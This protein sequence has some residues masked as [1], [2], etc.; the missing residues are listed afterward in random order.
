MNLQNDEIL[1]S[2]CCITYNHDKY[3]AQA[4]EGFL[5][6]KTTF[7]YEIII[8]EDCSTDKTRLILNEYQSKNPNKIRVITRD[9][10]VGALRNFSNVLEN[11]KGKYIAFC[12]GDDYWIDPLKLQK[13]VD[14]LE[15]N[16]DYVICCH[17]S[18]VINDLGDVTYSSDNLIPLIYS[19][20]DLVVGRRE[21]TRVAT[22]LM[23]N[24]KQILQIDQKE[25]FYR[26][27]G[28]DKFLKLYATAVTGMKIYVIPE[29]MSCYRIHIG[30]IWSLIDPKIRKSR[31]ISDFNILI[32][33]FSYSGI[34]RRRLLF[35]YVRDFLLFDIKNRRFGNACK[36]VLKLL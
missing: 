13:Q 4:I 12:D 22:V 16:P 33:N 11:A 35:I 18:K 6:Q 34:Q 17:Y 15:N 5:M 27:Y 3:I 29:I 2:V 24:N 10:N 28:T 26:T 31:M 14:F 7:K 36:S 8:G 32:D 19:Y 20:E 21:E 1:V 30:G 23:R 25:W 9:G